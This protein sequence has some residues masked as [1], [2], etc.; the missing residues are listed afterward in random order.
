MSR[1]F[2]RDGAR[3]RSTRQRDARIRRYLPVATFGE[4][5]IVLRPGDGRDRPG[6][7]S[8]LSIAGGTPLTLACDLDITAHRFTDD[9]FPNTSEWPVVV[10]RTAVDFVEVT[11]WGTDGAETF[12]VRRVT[13]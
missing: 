11:P 8:R 5:V 6:Q 7:V 10:L 1:A 2:D 13:L 3:S 4:D 12:H 9:F